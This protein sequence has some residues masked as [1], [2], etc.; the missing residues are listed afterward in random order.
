M[1]ILVLIEL[2]FVFILGLTCFY[3]ES[4]NS[5][6]GTPQISEGTLTRLSVS[7]G[8]EY[9]FVVIFLNACLSEFHLRHVGLLW[10]FWCHLLAN[11]WFNFG[12]M[13]WVLYGHFL[14]LWNFNLFQPK[15]MM[16][17]STYVACTET[18]RWALNILHNKPNVIKLRQFLSVCILFLLNEYVVDLLYFGVHFLSSLTSVA[19]FIFLQHGVVLF[20][21]SPL[22]Q[23]NYLIYNFLCLR[24][25]LL[26]I[27]E[28]TNAMKPHPA[29]QRLLQQRP[30]RSHWVH[31]TQE[32]ATNENLYGGVIIIVA[33]LFANAYLK[34]VCVFASVCVKHSLVNYYFY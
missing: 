10:G 32:G 11:I 24:I 5:H 34:S 7:E 19:L 25:S 31:L 13:S 28:T 8:S 16:F 9:E 26:L 14:Y 4:N 27:C 1:G 21:T 12:F 15:W 6:S 22:K 2:F 3:F 20:F 23:I 17:F 18:G 33:K 30:Y 29:R